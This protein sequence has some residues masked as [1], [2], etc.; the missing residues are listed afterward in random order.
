[1]T[2]ISEDDFQ[3]KDFPPM[4]EKLNNWNMSETYRRLDTTPEETGHLPFL[5]N[6]KN[7]CWR[8][9]DSNVSMRIRCLPY[10]FLVG[11]PKCGSTDL[12]RRLV[13]HPLISA[14]CRKEP[15]WIAR[16]RFAGGKSRN[17]SDYLAYYDRAVERDIHR[18]VTNGYHNA[19][20]GECN[21]VGLLGAPNAKTGFET[22]IKAMN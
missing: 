12:H 10:F 19:I 18:I 20:F 4:S 9:T 6:F 7:P 15:H 5:Q 16:K 11:A 3:Q 13:M 1:M 17:L 8:E 22:T 14:K 2:W 21:A